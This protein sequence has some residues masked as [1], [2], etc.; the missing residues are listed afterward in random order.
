MM[1]GVGLGHCQRDT[2]NGGGH[3]GLGNGGDDNVGLLKA[4]RTVEVIRAIICNILLLPC[5]NKSY[6]S[7]KGKECGLR[8]QNSCCSCKLINPTFLLLSWLI[9]KMWRSE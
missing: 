7:Y 4:L 2:D 1:A 6:A 5:L 9:Y 3:C 8:S